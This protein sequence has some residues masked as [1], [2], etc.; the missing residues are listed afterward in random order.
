MFLLLSTVSKGT[1]VPLLLIGADVC[2]RCLAGPF[3]H[4]FRRGIT[5][6][7][8]PERPDYSVRKS[9]PFRL[10]PLFVRRFLH[11]KPQQFVLLTTGVILSV[12]YFPV[13]S[14][15]ISSVCDLLTLSGEQRQ[16]KQ[17]IDRQRMLERAQTGGAVVIPF[18]NKTVHWFERSGAK[19]DWL[20]SQIHLDELFHKESSDEVKQAA[21]HFKERQHMDPNIWY[22]RL[23]KEYCLPPGYLEEKQHNKQQQQQLAE[24]GLMTQ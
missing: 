16:Q 20:E 7:K 24:Q 6:Y 14:G 23:W 5:E 22:N 1:R 18:T 17:Q 4:H 9:F 2:G 15:V 21:A 10:V 12:I 19:R 8:R 13:I 11:R 3:L